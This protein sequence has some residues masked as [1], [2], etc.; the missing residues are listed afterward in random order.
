MRMTQPTTT[1]GTAAYAQTVSSSPA[2]YQSR[3]SESSASRRQ[4]EMPTTTT[5]G[6]PSGQSYD[7]SYRRV[8]NPYDSMAGGNYSVAPS[9]TIPSI[10]G[11]TQSPLPSPHMSQSS[12]GQQIMPQ[13]S[14]S[15]FVVTHPVSPLDHEVNVATDHRTC[16]IPMAMDSLTQPHLAQLNYTPQVRTCHTH[17]PTPTEAQQSTMPWPNSP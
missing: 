5:A 9:Q 2:L 1:A 3:G 17:H 12:G 13:Y 16:T 10:S 7:Q 14:S 8:S 15:R 6:T 11:L 4:S